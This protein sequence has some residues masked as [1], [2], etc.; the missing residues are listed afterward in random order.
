M[1]HKTLY[2]TTSYVKPMNAFLV[3]QYKLQ[4]GQ[5]ISLLPMCIKLVF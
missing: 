3:D 4:M 5:G 2:Y 1:L